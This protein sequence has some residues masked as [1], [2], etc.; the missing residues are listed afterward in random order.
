MN[1]LVI[2]DS[3]FSNT[4]Q[5]AE[6]IGAS[7]SEL[8][9]V[10]VKPV[11]DQPEVTPDVALLVVGGPTHAHGISQ[12]MRAFL[13]ALPPEAIRD[14]PAASFDT[15]FHKPKWLV[16]AASEGIA[17]RLRKQGARIVAEPES[18]WV[19][20]G[21]GP[22]SA[23]EVERAEAWARTLLPSAVPVG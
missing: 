14:I 7:L 23:G 18:F 1:A 13:D 5:I 17:K 11:T 8:Y 10:S 19:D 16:G 6:A 4:R 3:K 12:P 9:D 22:L 21:E 2:Y 20:S 15:R